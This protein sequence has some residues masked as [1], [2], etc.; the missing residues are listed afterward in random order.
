MK[1]AVI[2]YASGK[3]SMFRHPDGV[4]SVSVG[5]EGR[6]FLA[7]VVCGD[8][9]VKRFHRI[10]TAYIDDDLETV[11]RHAGIPL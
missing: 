10:N 5:Y 4:A 11:C 3:K 1:C 2:E 9:S 7:K 8:G 6:E